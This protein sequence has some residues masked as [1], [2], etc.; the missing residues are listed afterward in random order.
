MKRLCSF[1]SASEELW[2]PWLQ[3]CSFT[4]TISLA[5]FFFLLYRLCTEFSIL[6]FPSGIFKTSIF[7][8]FSI[9]YLMQSNHLKGKSLLCSLFRELRG[10]GFPGP[11]FELK[12]FK[13]LQVQGWAVLLMVLAVTPTLQN[14]KSKGPEQLHRTFI[15]VTQ[16]LVKHCCWH[17]TGTFNKLH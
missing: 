15:S 7:S 11:V 5:F 3:P 16:Q 6:S 2:S 17:R 8:H 14:G 10:V 12:T 13:M 9:L 1:I 4:S